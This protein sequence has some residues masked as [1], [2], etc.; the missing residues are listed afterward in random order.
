MWPKTLRV[1]AVVV[2]TTLL[3][4]TALGQPA[5]N[6]RAAAIILFDEARQLMKR[7]DY[8]AACP[9]LAE[10]QRVGPGI[11]IL[12]NLSDCYEKVGK[13]AS[14]WAGFRKVAAQA[15]SAGQQERERDARARLKALKPKLSRLVIVVS[16]P[17]EGLRIR[18]NGEPVRAAQWGSEIPVDPGQVRLE[19]TAR[20]KKPWSKTVR[21]AQPGAVVRLELPLLEA[22][23]APSATPT[24]RGE[25]ASAPSNNDEHTNN[26]Q[27]PLG[28][29]T[30]ATGVAAVGVAAGVG[31]AAKSKAD[32]ADCDDANTCSEAGLVDRRDAVGLGNIA[33]GVMIAGGVL[34]AAGLTVWLTAPSA[35]QSDTASAGR[36]GIR[37]S[38]AALSL[39]LP[40]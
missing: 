11:G 28:I 40:F 10:A 39:A 35:D 14:A 15:K 29:A 2:A 13:T 4:G 33:T 21:I 37:I 3:A 19:A 23:T 16:Q 30:L 7:G 6:P 17:A 27:L 5:D 24:S 8:A 31:F 32:D 9:K 18:R 34:A 25:P 20:G 22:A 36:V 1:S 38:A 12:Y 26:W